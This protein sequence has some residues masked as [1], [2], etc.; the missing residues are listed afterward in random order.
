MIMYSVLKVGF[1][2]IPLSVHTKFGLAMLFYKTN[3][4]TTTSLL[5]TLR[6]A[7]KT[8]FAINFL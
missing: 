8:S 3:S 4:E 7:N 5:R 2:G 1:N 6:L